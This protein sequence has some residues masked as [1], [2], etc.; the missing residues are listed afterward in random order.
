MTEP[1]SSPARTRNRPPP[2][3][4][5]AMREV[6]ETLGLAI[7]EAARRMSMGPS[8]LGNVL[9]G[10]LPVDA[11]LALRFERLTGAEPTLYLHMQDELELWN[12]RRRLAMTLNGIKPAAP[13]PIKRGQ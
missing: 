11:D 4:G 3:P 8:E 9:D 12:A 6:L 10:V 1:P 7:S 2:H 13:L 5:E